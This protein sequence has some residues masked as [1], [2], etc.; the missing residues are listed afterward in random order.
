MPGVSGVPDDSYIF[1]LAYN[2]CKKGYQSVVYN[3]R[4]IEE[5]IFN[6]DPLDLVK[7]LDVTLTFLRE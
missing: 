7:D 4:L 5:S 2:L 3:Y 1:N 6:E